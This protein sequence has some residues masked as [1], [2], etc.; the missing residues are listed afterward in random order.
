VW[1]LNV[2]FAL[3]ILIVG[4]LIAKMLVKFLVKVL[5]RS[6]V[7]EML[8]TFSKSL[9]YGVLILLILAAALDRLG[10]NVSS[11]AAVLGAAGLT[12][13]LALQG[14]LQNFAAGVML[15]LFRPFKVGDWVELAGV[16]GLVKRV[17]VFTTILKT[18]DYR[19][20]FIPNSSIYKGNIV[21]Y[22]S[23]QIRRL[24]LPIRIN[25]TND[26]VLAKELIIQILQS[27]PQ[28]LPEPVPSVVIE[29]L[30]LQAVV[31]SVRPWVKS[32]LY[33]DI[34]FDLNEKIKQIFEQHGVAPPHVAAP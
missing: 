28:V 6:A 3:I 2:F 13:G 24:D 33:M 23:L 9:V 19:E 16:I 14:S 34:R 1:L 4:R 31:L 27:H 10:V 21:N 22:Y 32:E 30:S 15:L 8:I 12:I 7:D 29:E 17:G 11:F 18:G 26:V 5:R 20:V 25:Y